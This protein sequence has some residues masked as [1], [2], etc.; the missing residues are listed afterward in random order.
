[1]DDLALRLPVDGAPKLLDPPAPKRLELP[2]RVA[3]N[4]YT[5]NIDRAIAQGPIRDAIH[6]VQPACVRFPNASGCCISPDGVILTAAHVAGK[7]GRR[8][9]AT[10]PDGSQ[11]MATCTAFSDYLDLAVMKIEGEH[12]LPYASLAPDAPEVGD[13]IC[14][15]GQPGGHTPTGEP[16]G[17]GAFYVSTGQIRGFKTDRLGYQMLGAA[18]HDAWTYW[19][20]SGCPLFNQYG[21]ICAMHNSWDST[22]AMRHGVTYEAILHFLKESKVDFAMSE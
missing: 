4:P 16:T 20:H 12:G 15:I 8:M 18:K 10:F 22:T 5:A 7:L 3:D 6:A 2:H 13:W 21:Q 9:I 14:A 17:Y 1:L 11:H 19:G